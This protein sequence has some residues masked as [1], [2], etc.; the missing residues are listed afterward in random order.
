MDKDFE[1][2][3]IIEMKI[4][5][6]LA[7][8]QVR[9]MRLLKESGITQIALAKKV[10]ISERAATCFW[11]EEYVRKHKIRALIFRKMQRIV[12]PLEANPVQEGAKRG[13]PKLGE[14]VSRFSVTVT[15]SERTAL[16]TLADKAMVSLA[17]YVVNGALVG[18]LPKEISAKDLEL[19]LVIA[20]R[21]GGKIPTSVLC[22]ILHS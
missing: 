20:N 3:T 16:Q 14:G 22:S 5:P 4:K 1:S 17:R 12:T 11:S 7:E 15:N 18:A 10:G 9:V 6:E 19:M 2:T 8:E 13:R 21:C